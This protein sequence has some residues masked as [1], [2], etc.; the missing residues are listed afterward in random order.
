M[1]IQHPK[2]KPFREKQELQCN[3]YMP[4]SEND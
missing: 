2:I 1:N 3:E 4:N